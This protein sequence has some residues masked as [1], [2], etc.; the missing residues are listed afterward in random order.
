M[1]STHQM[2]IHIFVYINIILYTDNH[3]EMVAPMEISVEQALTQGNLYKF[4]SS[5][6]FLNIHIYIFFNFVLIMLF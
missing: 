4:E 3:E 5:V 1:Y 6:V 2:Y